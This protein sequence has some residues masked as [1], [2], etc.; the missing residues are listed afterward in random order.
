MPSYLRTFVRNKYETYLIY[1]D[2]VIINTFDDI[3]TNE[4]NNYIINNSIAL[5]NYYYL[6]SYNNGSI[7]V[8]K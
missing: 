6:R 1:I 7:M 5:F 3:C 4:G 8:N 2:Y